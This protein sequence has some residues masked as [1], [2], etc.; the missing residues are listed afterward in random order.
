MFPSTQFMVQIHHTFFSYYMFRPD[1][2]IL[3]YI[4]TQNHL[5]LLLILPP[6]WP[7]FTQWECVVCMVL[8]DALC[9]ET[10]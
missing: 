4:R 9:Y 3:R 6:H 8:Y 2:A 7:V 5:F 10:Y 1:G